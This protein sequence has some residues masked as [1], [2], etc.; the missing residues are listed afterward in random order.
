MKLFKI[1]KILFILP[2]SGDAFYCG[3]C[4]RDNLQ[5]SALRRAGH[6]VIVMPLYLPLT[7]SAFQADTPLFFPATS[8]YVAHGFFRQRTM[9]GWMRRMLDSKFVLKLAASFAGATSAEGM[10]GITLSM[11]YGGDSA[12]H[13]QVN[14][15]IDWIEH[16]ER[17][18]I[19]HFS[20]PLLIGI[21]K[22]IN[23]RIRLPIV[24]S[25]QDEEV[26]IDS[27]KTKFSDIAWKGIL[28]NINYVD[29]FITTSEFYRKVALS[30]YP[31]LKDVEVVY[32]GVEIAE[33]A[34]D[35]YP[36][37][38]VI[39]FFYRMNRINGLEILVDAFVKLKNRKSIPNL[40]LKIGGGYTTHDNKFMRSIRKKLSQYADDVEIKDSYQLDDH[41][42]FYSEISVIC[43][44][45]TFDEGVGLYLCEAF[46]AGRP[47]VE[48]ATGSFEEIVADAGVVYSP[49]SSDALAD[50][51][52]KIL[53][54][55]VLY[56]TYRQH[57]LQLSANRYNSHVFAEKLANLYKKL[58]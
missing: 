57:A 48:P 39:G 55:S 8:F 41:A 31:E 53:S 51:L 11:I 14:K 47:A 24:C 1:M 10:E 16:H 18:D 23:Q 29:K 50:A 17:P 2:G 42:K 37:S 33:Y 7:D 56:E 44:P 32:P 15:L 5:A 38:P 22:A 6:E 12:F 28:E 49:N 3:N 30:K 20:S 27:L 40:K 34:S 52:E 43:V 9:P 46:A 21:A 4:F 26:W 13:E 36:E 54:D 19:I 45:L 58:C 35:S 25:L